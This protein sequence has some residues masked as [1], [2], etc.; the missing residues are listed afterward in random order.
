MV[1]QDPRAS[2]FP[3]PRFLIGLVAT[4]VVIVGLLTWWFLRADSRTSLP[5]GPLAHPDAAV[6]PDSIDL[7]E[8]GPGL[9][10]SVFSDRAFGSPGGIEIPA[11]VRLSGPG[12]LSGRVLD[13][14]SGEPL[15]GVRIDLLPLP[16]AGGRAF[17]RILH[18]ANTGDDLEKRVE[19][20]AIT[21]TDAAGAFQFEGVRAGQYF[22]E[23]RGTRHVPD[24][25]AHA[26][27]L[28]SGSG[29]P[30][31]V[32]LRPGGRVVGRV[33]NPDGSPAIGARMAITAGPTFAI[34]AAR[35]GDIVYLETTSGEQGAFVFCGVPEGPDWQVTASGGRFALTHVP[36]LA[37]RAGEDTQVVVRTHSGCQVVGRI[38]S[39]PGA[40][41]ESST[42]EATPLAGA[43]V[44]VVPRGL[45][46][47]SYVSEILEATHAVTDGEG[48]YTMSFVPAGEVDVLAMAPGHLPAQGPR[49]IVP[50]GGSQ[51]APDFLLP[52]GPLV[53]GRVL[54]SSGTPLE[55]V[56][57]RWN[58]VDLRNFNFDFSFAPLLAQAVKGF[59]FPKTDAEG[60]FSAGAFPGEKPYRIEFSRIGYES[61]HV[62]WDPDQDKELSVTLRSGG[63]VEG[64]V[65]NALEHVPVTS[66]RV[67]G[68]DRIDNEVAAPGRRNPY[69]G[70]QEIEDAQGKFRIESVQP[71][72]KSLTFNAPGFLPKTVTGLEVVEGQTLR[73]V[74]VELT[75]GGVVHGLVKNKEGAPVAGAAVFANAGKEFTG[76]DP[77]RNRRRGPFAGESGAGTEKMG[78]PEDLPAGMSGFMAQLGMFGDRAV[79]SK[80]DGSFEL[81][82][83]EEGEL[84]LYA[85]HRDYVLGRAEPVQLTADA[86]APEILITMAR[87]SGIFG[88]ATDRFDRP[89]KGAI[90][91]ALSP[92][93]LGG[94]G[95]STGGGLYQGNTDAEGR[96]SIDHVS[97]GSYFVLLTR[98]D[99]ALNPMSFLGTLNFDLVSVPQDERVQKDIVDTSS[100]ACRVFGTV[101]AAG[102][103]LGGG[104][105][106]A[107]GFES[108]NLLGVDFKLAQ[109]QSD[110]SFE[111][112]GLAPGEYTLQVTELARGR[113]PDQI[114][115]TVEIPDLPETRIDLRLPQGGIEGKVVAREGG[116]VLEGCELILA[117]EDAVQPSGLFG[118]LVSRDNG[119]ARTRTNARGE[120][121]FDRLQAGSYR[122]S[123]RPP[124]RDE[125]QPHFAQ[126]TPIE[127]EVSEGET[128]RDLSIELAPALAIAG[129]VRRTN[130]DALEGVEVIA[131]ANGKN[132]LLPERAKSDA[133]GHFRIEN[134][135]AGKYDL[136]AD[137]DGFATAREQAHQLGQVSGAEVVLVMAEGVEFSVRVLSPQGQPIAGASGNLI[138]ESGDTRGFADA[139]RML[140]SLFA[141][142]GVSNSK[143][144]L[145]L[146]NFA[147]GNYQLE[148]SR[149]SL[150][151]KQ[152]VKLEEGPPQTLTVRLE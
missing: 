5:A 83:L 51:T 60:R 142:K 141:G 2:E 30:V 8:P 40:N 139:G 125:G 110:G 21:G 9:R 42:A 144:L 49:V 34:E 118:Q 48:R 93:N 117:R 14:S 106:A 103:N 116:E 89:V 39:G 109:I 149:G 126:P 132:G 107:F 43:D 20:I 148:V 99:E 47:L 143:G 123:L 31:D 102:V 90:V 81:G 13:R 98:G 56:V 53:Q 4:F 114:K 61:T 24:G 10:Q 45:R 26:R 50:D 11:G 6:D 95:N 18:L 84:T 32:F 67:S 80:A 145:A 104:S 52:R 115:L 55:G 128:L 92:A 62:D 100:G 105:I 29:G 108:E 122:L 72:P 71:G 75:P 78:R 28:A 138:S 79:L 23:A 130:G 12:R 101:S 127:V 25:V 97:A 69:S 59:E 124:R 19:P 120:F 15:A 77:G 151:A 85:S 44:G 131:T 137:K 140:T 96:Y 68:K 94:Q 146:G 86:P 73:G 147:P 41:E 35:T 64:V 88:T 74:I 152:A 1:V 65:M 38:L 63:A 135:S 27:V 37:V 112:V 16:P 119:A 17:G 7:G 58:M 76:N 82:G 136:S 66:F 91:L 129:V 87:G 54:T 22:L 121:S 150:R 70:G 3:Q 46:D 113:R 134:L 133:Q 36:E 33:E 111:F 57:V